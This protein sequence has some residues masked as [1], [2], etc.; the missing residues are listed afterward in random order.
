MI[1]IVGKVISSMFPTSD[2]QARSSGGERY[3]DTVEVVGS[4]PIVPTTT[5]QRAY[6]NIKLASSFFMPF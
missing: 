5:I 1:N 4:N 2:L 3:P 6:S